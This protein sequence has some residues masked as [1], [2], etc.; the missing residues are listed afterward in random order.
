M[1]GGGSGGITLSSCEVSDAADPARG[2]MPSILLTGGRMKKQIG[3]RAVMMFSWRSQA[4]LHGHPHFQPPDP[5][6]R[7]YR[8]TDLRF[9]LSCDSEELTSTFT[10]TLD[11]Y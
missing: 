9:K 3:T 6:A 7:E 11:L 5:Q 1:L 4:A 10:V 2:A 8:L